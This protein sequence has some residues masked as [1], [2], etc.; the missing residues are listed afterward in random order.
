MK[1]RM[2]WCAMATIALTTSCTTTTKKGYSLTGQVDSSLD[3]TSV[4]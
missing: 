1:K 4:V 2:F 3:R